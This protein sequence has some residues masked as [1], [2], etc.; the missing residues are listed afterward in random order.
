MKK[1]LGIMVPGLLLTSGVSYAAVAAEVIE[2][3][4]E[5]IKLYEEVVLT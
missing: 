1:L 3:L 4:K 2:E 5:C